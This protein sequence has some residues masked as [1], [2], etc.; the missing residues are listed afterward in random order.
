[1][2]ARRAGTAGPGEFPDSTTAG[3][4]GNCACSAFRPASRS[5]RSTAWPGVR[6]TAA[7]RHHHDIVA[8]FQA[9]GPGGL[10]GNQDGQAVPHLAI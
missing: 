10:G 9:Q 6:R 2:R 8:R 3:E 5:L 7:F 1:M 4:V